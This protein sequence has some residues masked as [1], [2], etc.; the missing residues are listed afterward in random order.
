MSGDLVVLVVA[1]A[2]AAAVVIVGMRRNLSAVTREGLPQF[3]DSEG[4]TATLGMYEG[5]EMPRGPLSPRQRHGLAALYLLFALTEVVSAVRSSDDRLINAATAA[6][7]V[8]AAV[9]LWRR[10]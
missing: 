1:L 7:I 6:M 9:V 3:G 5:E 2:V 4:Q 10:K 8:L